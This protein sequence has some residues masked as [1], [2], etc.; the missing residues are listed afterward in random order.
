MIIKS[1]PVYSRQLHSTGLVSG[2][3]ILEY[4]FGIKD[5]SLEYYIFCIAITF[6]FNLGLCYRHYK[7]YR[8]SRRG[9]EELEELLWE[10]LSIIFI[11]TPTM[12]LALW[13]V[14]SIEY[15]HP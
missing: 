14:T 10:L 5:W 8:K 15:S 12:A 9:E 6:T 4:F 13:C 1:L 2:M 11:Y 7:E 3:G